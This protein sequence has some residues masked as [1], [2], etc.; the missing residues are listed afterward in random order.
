M[1]QKLPCKCRAGGVTV[2]ERLDIHCYQVR[3]NAICDVR[4]IIVT[5][6]NLPNVNPFRPRTTCI[7]EF[8][9]NNFNLSSLVAVVLVVIVLCRVSRAACP[10][11]FQINRTNLL[12]QRNAQRNSQIVSISCP[13][14]SSLSPSSLSSP[15]WDSS[16]EIALRCI[17]LIRAAFFLIGFATGEEHSAIPRG[18]MFRVESLFDL[19]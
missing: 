4:D 18:S 9:Y 12:V 14:P 7:K 3:L 8:P 15:E 5:Y 1:V 16:L 6:I 17:W 13:N 11:S 19:L 10:H 2:Y